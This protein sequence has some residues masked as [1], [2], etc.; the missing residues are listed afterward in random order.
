MSIKSGFRWTLEISLKKGF[1]VLRLEMEA[2]QP[3][4]LSMKKDE[5]KIVQKSQPKS[6]E[7]LSKLS[8]L[9]KHPKALENLTKEKLTKI[10][11]YR[12]ILICETCFKIFDRPS[13][14]TR[15]IR[16]HTGALN[17]VL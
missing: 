8:V 1:E 2:D 10:Q 3:L 6:L 17:H 4:D 14:L 12:N 11:N 5:A 9:M 15:H 13:L 16:S 7:I